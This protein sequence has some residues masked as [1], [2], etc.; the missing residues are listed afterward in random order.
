MSATQR[1]RLALVVRGVMWLLDGLIDLMSISRALSVKEQGQ[2]GVD[3]CDDLRMM[4]STRV[5]VHVLYNCS[6]TPR[7]REKWKV[8]SWSR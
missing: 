2:N 3:G 7:P 6:S 1:S 4:P 8:A 5:R